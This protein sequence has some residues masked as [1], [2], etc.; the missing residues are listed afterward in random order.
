MVQSSQEIEAAGPR[1][2]DNFESII[3]HDLR[4][5]SSTVATEA[6]KVAGQVFNCLFNPQ[7]YG[8]DKFWSFWQTNFLGRN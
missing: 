5:G 4:R 6:G 2:M 3:F 1:H 8:I 7:N